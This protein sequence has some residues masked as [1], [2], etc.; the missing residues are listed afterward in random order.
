MSH[1]LN[2][3]TDAENTKTQS[4]V[5]VTPNTVKK[6]SVPSLLFATSR[7]PCIFQNGFLIARAAQTERQGEVA[8]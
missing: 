2:G 4:G 6:S 7:Q 8:P 1:I 3:P 5:D